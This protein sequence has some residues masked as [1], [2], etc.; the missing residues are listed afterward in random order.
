[1]ILRS[2]FALTLVYSAL[3]LQICCSKWI[4]LEW[5]RPQ[6]LLL[7]MIFLAL[8]DRFGL[9]AVSCAGIGFLADSLEPNGMGRYFLLYSLT[10][11]WLQRHAES[12]PLRSN[13]ATL[14]LT[15]GI[16][17]FLIPFSALI[18]G[19]ALQPQPIEFLQSSVR[20]LFS[21]LWTT[22]AS[23]PFLGFINSRSLSTATYRRNNRWS[24][25]ADS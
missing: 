23:I 13:R 7:A 19:L 25:L 16:A 12:R 3:I 4:P 22:L 21:S 6:P 17:S 24:V 11:W 8:R 15:I 5:G 9:A 10:G 1:M 14:L 18:L 20:T 2:L